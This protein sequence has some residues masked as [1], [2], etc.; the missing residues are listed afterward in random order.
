MPSLAF[1]KA[2]ICS[3]FSFS[4]SCT[5]VVNPQHATRSRL[6][7][8]WKRLS[9]HSSGIP[10]EANV[11]NDWIRTRRKRFG[12]ARLTRDFI[13]DPGPLLSSSTLR[14]LITRQS[15]RPAAGRPP[16]RAARMKLIQLFLVDGLLQH[17]ARSKLG[18]LPGRNLNDA[19]RLRIASVARLTLRDGE[20]AESHQS[21]TVA[22]LQ[23]GRDRIDYCVDRAAGAGFA[24]S[25]GGCDFFNQIPFVHARS[26][27]GQNLWRQY[28][29]AKPGPCQEKP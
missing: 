13:F 3:R 29:L 4:A 1:R 26:S 24:D 27:P 10:A 2:S 23:R 20:G 18:N 28:L 12:E 8:Y 14:L 11:L 21:H 15:F 7:L 6:I 25:V 9:S 5:L 17:D 22:F 16:R 19:S